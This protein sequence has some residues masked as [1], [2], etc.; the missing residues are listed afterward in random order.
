MLSSSC[1]SKTCCDMGK[2]S[3]CLQHAR[4]LCSS[5]ERPFVSGTS[6][7]VLFV[8][9]LNLT[10]SC[11]CTQLQ[12]QSRAQRRNV[13]AR[14]AEMERAAEVAVAE[15]VREEKQHIQQLLARFAFF[16]ASCY[17]LEMFQISCQRSCWLSIDCWSDVAPCT[18]KCFCHSECT[19]SHVSSR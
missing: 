8:V 9:R 15:P 5:L 12:Q 10:S 16:C 14:V 4:Q 1:G 3:G 7:L 17:T 18:Q 13:R 19:T 2:R 11:R 6:A